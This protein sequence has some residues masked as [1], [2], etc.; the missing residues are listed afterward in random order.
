MQLQKLPLMQLQ[1]QLLP[2]PLPTC[3][4][5]LSPLLKLQL[6]VKLPPL[7]LQLLQEPTE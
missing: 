7:M 4:H 6:K 5:Q 2:P 3:H 1:Q